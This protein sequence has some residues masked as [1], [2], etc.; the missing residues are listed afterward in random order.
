M[1]ACPHCGN[2]GISRMRKMFL[3]PAFP[4]RCKVCGKVVGVPW[5]ATFA[6]IPFMVA[7]IGAAFVEPLV[8]KAAL[9]VAGWVVMSIIHMVWVPLEPR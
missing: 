2:P 5:T 1:Y 6:A 9:W 7:V 4:A 3:G 8:A